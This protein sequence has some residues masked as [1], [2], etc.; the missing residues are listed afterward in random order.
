MKDEKKKRMREIELL[1]SETKDSWS[2]R[3]VR[4][5]VEKLEFVEEI[6]SIRVVILNKQKT[7]TYK[8]ALKKLLL[9]KKKKER[10]IYLESLVDT[11]D[12]LGRVHAFEFVQRHRDSFHFIPVDFTF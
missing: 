7:N 11:S 5:K 12:R 2:D 4:D 1:R 10:Y 6:V 8:S 9:I 3:I